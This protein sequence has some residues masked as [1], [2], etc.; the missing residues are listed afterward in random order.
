MSDFSHLAK[1]EPQDTV[2]YVLY[3]IQGEPALIM[4]PALESNKPYFNAI[5]K[6]GRKLARRA[7]RNVNRAMLRE[8]RDDDRQIYPKHIIRGWEKVVDAKNKPVKFTED[9][10]VAFLKAMPDWVFDELRVFASNPQ[11]FLDEEV[12]TDEL[13]EGSD[14]D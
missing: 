6:K 4:A 1:L 8:A 14:K 9:D 11:N 7:G 12:D 10:C 3:Q 13:G 2:K 5:L